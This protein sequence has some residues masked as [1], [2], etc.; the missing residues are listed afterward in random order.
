MRQ[1][2]DSASSPALGDFV[3]A[4]LAGR[5]DHAPLTRRNCQTMAASLI[6]HLGVSA[7]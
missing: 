3:D 4:Y 7:G 5:T 2:T 1:V 6:A